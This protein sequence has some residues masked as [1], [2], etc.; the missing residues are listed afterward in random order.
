MAAVNPI[1]V[2]WHLGAN[3]FLIDATCAGGLSGAPVCNN[4][5]EVLGILTGGIEH[6]VPAISRQQPNREP[7]Y[8]ISIPS[9]IGRMLPLNTQFLAQVREF[10][11]A[12]LS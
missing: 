10:V 1:G 5:G 11:S 2:K 3:E 8:A 4:Q 9:N 7:E 6:W 12:Q